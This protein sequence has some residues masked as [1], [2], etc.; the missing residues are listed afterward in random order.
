MPTSITVAPGLTMSAPTTCRRPTAATRT[1]ASSVWRSRSLGARV[2]DRDGRVGLEQQVRDRLADD[3]AAADD[4]RPRALQ[5]RSRTPRAAR[6]IPSGVAGTSAGRP[7][8]SWPAFAGWKPSTSFAGSTASMTRLSSRC[9]GSGSWTRIPSTASSAFS[10]ATSSR[11]SSSV[12][13]AG[14]R[15]SCGVDPGRL[16][17]LV[18]A[19]DVDVRRRVV[20]DEHGREPHVAELGD[21]ERRPPRAPSP[22]GPCRRSSAPSP[23]RRYSLG[24]GKVSDTFRPKGVRHFS[25]QGVRHFSAPRC[26]TLFGARRWPKLRTW[27]SDS[28]ARTTPPRSPRDAR[29]SASTAR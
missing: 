2:A 27:R 29:R 1:S 17:R 5:P 19:A 20:A 24:R 25:A 21:L 12:V 9:A 13:S 6:M 8:Y 10:S 16:R 3:V 26:Q 11:S 4:D 7:R 14:R 18:L 15:W 23:R 28:P 22:P